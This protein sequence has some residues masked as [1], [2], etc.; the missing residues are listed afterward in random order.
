MDPAGT[1][2]SWRRQGELVF[3]LFP[4][5]VAPSGQRYR[6]AH[7]RGLKRAAWSLAPPSEHRAAGTSR[8]HE[9][10]RCSDPAPL[11][12]PCCSWSKGSPRGA[13]GM[14]WSREVRARKREKNSGAHS[15]R[16]SKAPPAI[17][18]SAPQHGQHLPG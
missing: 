12:A 5:K 13:S 6:E 11:G 18:A 16:T 4:V 14:P 2:Q 8:P 7:A 15:K 9:Q 1:V 10:S 3:I 17:S